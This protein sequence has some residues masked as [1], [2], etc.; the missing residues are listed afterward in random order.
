MF[1]PNAQFYDAGLRIQTRWVNG[2]SVTFNIESRRNLAAAAQ[3]VLG[4]G[5][6]TVRRQPQRGT[7]DAH[8]GDSASGSIQ[9]RG[10][11]AARANLHL[12]V[13][14]CI[15]AAPNPLM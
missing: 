15:A 12:F 5:R 1:V 14:N 4:D 10:A 11:Y 7:G 3:H 2:A 9:N 6:N 13:V 8:R